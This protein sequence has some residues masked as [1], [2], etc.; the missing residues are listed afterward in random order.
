MPAAKYIYAATI[1]YGHFPQ[2]L[3]AAKEIDAY[4]RAQKA[5]VGRYWTPLTG[6]GNRVVW[7]AQ[8]SSLAEMEKEMDRLEWDEK[9]LRLRQKIGAES[10]EGSAEFIVWQELELGREFK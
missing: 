7:E 9:H 3:A 10:I 5:A 4:E 1:K 2:F 8:Y 6:P